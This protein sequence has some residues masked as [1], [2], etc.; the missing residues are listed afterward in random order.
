M[1]CQPRECPNLPLF[2]QYPEGYL[3][4]LREKEAA[5]E[6]AEAEN[7]SGKKRKRKSKVVESDGTKALLSPSEI[8]VI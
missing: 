5:L 6:A 7:G 1:L 4:N 8:V 3:E 2:S